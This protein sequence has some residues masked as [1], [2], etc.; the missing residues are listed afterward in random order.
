MILT[1]IQARLG[2]TR[3]PGKIL[4]PIA[5]RPILQHV[6][7]AAPEPKV[8]ALPESDLEKVFLKI[9]GVTLFCP[10]DPNDVLGRF[11]Y[12]YED[13]S[14]F[15]PI[16]WILRLTADCPMLTRELVDKFITQSWLHGADQFEESITDKFTIYTN[17]PYDADGYDME[18]FSVE[19]LKMAHE[20]AT[21]PHDREHVTAWMYRHLNVERF[22]VFGRMPQPENPME[23]VSVDT[24][25]DYK[26]VKRIME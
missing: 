13:A 21:D 11:F 25:E 24:E 18:L 6:Y 12:T 17:R 23:K 15:M 8:V 26:T 19:A 10:G 9:N 1:I 3:L 20:H 22:S 14:K 16:T 4:M 5:G 7:D 2:S